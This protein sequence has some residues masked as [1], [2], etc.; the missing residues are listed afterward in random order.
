MDIAFSKSRFS[1]L[2]FVFFSILAIFSN[3]YATECI[4]ARDSGNLLSVIV[5]AN[6]DLAVTNGY[7]NESGSQIAAWTD[8][9]VYTSGDPLYFEIEG[10]WTPWS[11]TYDLIGGDSIENQQEYAGLQQKTSNAFFCNM[12]TKNKDI[13]VFDKGVKHQDTEFDYISSLIKEV[14]KTT[15]DYQ[16]IYFP[17]EVQKTCWLTAGEGLYIGFFGPTGLESPDLATHLKLAEIKCDDEF[18]KDLND[19]GIFT[20]NECLY[21]NKCLKQEC[22]EEEKKDGTNMAYYTP[23]SADCDSDFYHKN[24]HYNYFPK[25]SERKTIGINDCYQDINIAGNKI[26]RQDKTTFV[27]RAGYLY[28]NTKKDIVGKNER[29]KFIIY[30][31]YYSDNVGQYKIKMYSG[32]TDYTDKG[33][34]EK[35]IRDLEDVF[36]GHRNEQGIFENGILKTMYDYLV[37]D[38]NFNFIVRMAVILYM[39]FLSLSF[40]L[41]SLEYNRK[42][43]M[44][45]LLKLTF[46][47]A[48][49]TST[50]WQLYDRYIVKFFYDGFM[51]II[52]VIGNLSSKLLKS[53]NV[54]GVVNSASMASAFYFIDNIILTLFSKA[55]TAKI[56]GLFFGVWYGFIVIPIIYFLILKYVYSLVNAIFPYLVM[57]IQAIFALFFGPIFIIFSLFK[58]TE[59]IFKAWL[60]FLGGR[61][62]NMMFLFTV[63]YMFWMIIKQEFD[64]LLFFNSCKVPLWQAIFTDSG[65]SSDT[66]KA[67]TNFF[68]F[69][70]EVWKANWENLTPPREIPGF[71]SF[72]FSLI[73]IYFLIYLFDMI[74]KKIPTI[75][76]SMFAVDGSSKG[77]GLKASNGT[78]KFGGDIGG[79]FDSL[80]KSI[81]IRGQGITQFARGEAIK[82]GKKFGNKFNENIL[83]NVKKRTI[84]RATTEL[85]R[86]FDHLAM[87]SVENM[88]DFKNNGTKNNDLDFKINKIPNIIGMLS[89]NVNE[90]KKTLIKELPGIMQEVAT[91][92][93]MKE[94]AIE[95]LDNLYSN[96][97]DKNN[98][99]GTFDEAYKFKKL[100]EF[101]TMMSTL[102]KGENRN[103]QLYGMNSKIVNLR[104]LKDDQLETEKQK[105]E[106]RQKLIKNRDNIANEKKITNLIDSE[107][108]QLSLDKNNIFLTYIDYE[109]ERRTLTKLL[110]KKTNDN[111]ILDTYQ[112]FM[113]K[114]RELN[115]QSNSFFINEF[116]TTISEFNN[117]YHNG[118]KLN[119]IYQDIDS[120][121]IAKLSQATKIKKGLYLDEVTDLL[122]LAK[123]LSEKE[124]NEALLQQVKEELKTIKEQSQ[125]L[126]ND[127]LVLTGTKDIEDFESRLQEFDK[128]YKSLS[129]DNPLKEDGQEAVQ[130]LMQ[131]GVVALV[132]ADLKLPN[133][134][135]IDA[136]HGGMPS[137]Q[138]IEEVANAKIED[139]DQAQKIKE[140]MEKWENIQKKQAEYMQALEEAQ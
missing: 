6:P 140:T 131:G 137:L 47:L 10:M 82:F 68:S 20:F 97:F 2:S 73:F 111:K 133:E 4:Y 70:I 69:G 115:E 109:S 52:V 23:D 127:V 122:S 84:D 34:I 35:I 104:Q 31:N 98:K 36:I 45:I 107:T 18:K 30:D 74:V 93:M 91:E 28:K 118:E 108:S 135:G 96:F 32:F 49:T 130:F 94:E 44:K 71:F 39:A 55:I 42:E 124:G 119:E 75:V 99:R 134:G 103:T 106:Y 41:G 123:G 17:D 19:D 37:T 1:I 16:K 100:S 105:I 63:I 92:R 60:T 25:G 95:K 56:L 48:F 12:S 117:R 128:V 61:F 67:V 29:I 46:V 54:I 125:N 59:H 26:I 129:N 88:I 9:K 139:K 136:I 58:T 138:P 83:Q 132:E 112:T 65:T 15:N 102:I 116:D 110:S 38:S 126:S 24:K 89:P 85:K 114:L 77:A 21:K 33:L 120:N 72:C 5:P 62:A 40:A 3:S 8:S 81:K 50:S 7:T 22:T 86:P 53:E 57:F 11:T 113:G 64:S 121:T 78:S 80:D 87:W 51:S 27:F 14:N 76:D 66:I 13:E 90:F 101:D 79:L 43:L